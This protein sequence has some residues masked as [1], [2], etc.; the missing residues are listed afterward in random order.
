MLSLICQKKNFELYREYYQYAK[1]LRN[2]IENEW[3]LDKFIEKLPQRI[4]YSIED[5]VDK[6][7][8]LLDKK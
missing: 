4:L 5:K 1:T 7:L 6:L 8:D 2:I 3:D